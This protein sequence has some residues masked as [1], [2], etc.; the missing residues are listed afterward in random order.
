[1]KLI[2]IAHHLS[3]LYLILGKLLK[4]H[5]AVQYVGVAMIGRYGI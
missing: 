3:K 5:H 2:M 1:M 4:I